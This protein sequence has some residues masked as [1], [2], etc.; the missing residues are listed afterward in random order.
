MTFSK[1][2]LQQIQEKNFKYNFRTITTSTD[3]VDFINNIEELE[4]S[5]EEVSVIIVL[6]TKNHILSYSEVARGGA[7]CC[8]LDMKSIFKRVLLCNGTKFILVH[9]HPS[10]VTDISKH[11]KSITKKIQEA[12]KIMDIEFVD[13][14]VIGAT[15]YRSCLYSKKV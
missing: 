11:D 4:K 2:K 13:H 15:E 12:S 9:N 1:I 10:G 14:I 6:N 5:T 7:N 3:V 8:N